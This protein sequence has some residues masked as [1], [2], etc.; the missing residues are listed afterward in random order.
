MH[1]RT[2]VHHGTTSA[3]AENTMWVAWLVLRVWNYL[4]VRGEYKFVIVLIYC[5]WELPPRARRIRG[6]GGRRQCGIGTTS[7]CA[8]N[9]MWVAW[10][11]LRVWNYLR[12]RGEYRIKAE[13]ERKLAELPPRARR[14]HI[15]VVHIIAHGGTTSAC[16]EN[17]A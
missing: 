17:T 10:L 14:I 2:L 1:T 15:N 12:V 3:C 11:V 9:T 4:R 16:A 13:R 8:E 5:R 7:A 6:G